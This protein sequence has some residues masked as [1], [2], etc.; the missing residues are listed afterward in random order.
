MVSISQNITFNQQEY[1]QY[2]KIDLYS[3]RFSIVEKNFQIK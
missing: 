3:W 2:L 1:V